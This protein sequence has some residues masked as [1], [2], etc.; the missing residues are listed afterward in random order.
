MKPD[1]TTDERG[2][3]RPRNKANMNAP[4]EEFID[5]EGAHPREDRD[6]GAEVEHLTHTT[7]WELGVRAA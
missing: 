2:H 1:E 4:Q 7:L 6:H 5:P 3:R